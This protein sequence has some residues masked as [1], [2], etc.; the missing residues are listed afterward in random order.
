MKRILASFARNTVFA[1]I[2][3][4]LIFLAGWMSVKSMIREM[5]PEFS[6][7]MITISVPFPGAD[8]EEVEEGISR[9][10]EEAVEGIEGIKQYTTKSAEGAGTAIVEVKENY[11]VSEV[12]D[13]VRSKV[14][15][16]STFPADAEK[17][18]ISEL[19]IKDSVMVI[20]L[21][22]NMT[23]RRL[24][25]WAQEMKDDIQQ[26][27]D[28]S[29]VTIFGVREYEIGIEVSE[30]RLREYGLSFDQV[31]EAVRRSNMNL[32][33]GTI[34][35]KGEEVRVR[36]IGRKYTGEELSKIVVLARPEGEII[37]LDRLA[38][39]DDGF[40]EDPVNATIN[41]EPS[42][43]LNVFKTKE[44]DALVISSAVW[45]FI[46][47][48][49][50]QVPEGA[51]IKVIYETTDMLRARIDLLTRNGIIGLSLVFILLWLFLDVRLSFWAG[52][53]VPISLG[54]GMV[55]L[56]AIGGTINMISLFGFI[57]V[58]GI[59]VDDAIVVGEAIFYHRRQGMPPLKAAVEGICEVG[60]PIIAAIVTTIIAFLP[61]AYIS[62][63]M[64][65]FIAILPATVIA[66][67]VVSLVECLFLLPAHLSHLPD[68]NAKDKTKQNRLIRRL[69]AIHSLSGRG[70]EWFVE[71][72]Y[73]P[74]LE[75]ALQWRYFSFC[76]AICILFLSIGLLRGGI[77]KF[78]VFPEV[79]G[80]IVLSN[81]EFP[82]GTPP[83]VVERAIAQIDEA[84]LRV[85]DRMETRSGDPLVVERLALTG[86]TV[87]DEMPEAG[88]HLGGMIVTLLESEK[89][90]I[91]SKD[92]MVE[93]EKEVGAIPGIKSLTFGGMAHGPPGA[94]VEIWLQG[95]SMDDILAASND[96]MGRLQKFDGVNQVRSDYSPGK[97]ELRLEL[98]PEARTMGLTVA[99]LA[100]QVYSGYYGEEAVR[101]QRGR[102]DIRVKVRYTADERS[103][104]SDIQ[105]VR[106]RTPNGYEVPLL[107]VADISFSPGY[108]AITRTDGMRRVVVSAG[109]DTNK[110]NADE[111]ISK[112]S[113][114][115]FPQMR[116]DY[117]GLYVSAE[118]EKKKTR[119]SFGSLAVGYPM[120][121]IGIFIIIATMFRS[122]IQPFVIM[123][124]IPFG[125]IGAVMGHLLMGYNLSMMSI[126]GMVALT[127]VVV[128]D[129]IVLIERINENIAE[130]MP[131]FEAIK[132]GGAR[133]FRAIF[134][135]T[136]STVG[137][138]APL[139]METDFQAKFLIPMAISIAA[140]VA[141][142][143]VLTLVLIPSLLAILNDMRRVAHWLFHG[144]VPTREEVE[145]SRGRKTDLYED[146]DDAPKELIQKVG[147]FSNGYHTEQQKT[148]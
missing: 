19:T 62:G 139:I 108:S 148:G 121:L 113:A 126:F 44:E 94:P 31:I 112:L 145:P 100:R 32:A 87:G 36:T 60:M 1:N 10:L 122:Y 5:F 111:I 42:V 37:T 101:L 3:L 119:E 114:E 142:A 106:I 93:W 30:E 144:Y 123:F 77:V 147:T 103:R 2:L 80:F 86:S 64:G 104:L 61:L 132:V 15:S 68:P 21:S 26:L 88:P 63:V 25:E 127:G 130:G 82:N 6:L 22:G 47:M 98:K 84:L 35:T 9:K 70:L 52:M 27:P 90:G 56:W 43:L 129:A 24:K 76:T 78:E 143:T 138:L 115:Y 66:C 39:I 117:P 99:D 53:G 23:D 33:G 95:H 51:K 55:V 83:D 137:G 57:M 116:N 18:V 72:I 131:F 67:L 105:Q 146:D 12:L 16:I 14:D 140:G 41:G 28:V 102:D 89:R 97:N 109:L 128:N 79:D 74:F 38:T 141:F 11:D 92:I 59:V 91:H 17:P 73:T 4:L 29:H 125:I 118:G 136:I 85:A 135:T 49:Q 50:K 75:K 13:K 40:T 20:S 65:K 45:D 110:A 124:T 58:L 71:H 34:R 46:R 133:R 7:D 96:L 81:V 48:K 134:L 8:P 107:S 69:K 120:A 54:G